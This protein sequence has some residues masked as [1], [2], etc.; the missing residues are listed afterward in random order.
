MK[1][2]TNEFVGRFLWGDTPEDVLWM[3]RYTTPVVAGS[4]ADFMACANAILL[5]QGR[6]AVATTDARTFL[7]GLEAQGVLRI[8]HREDYL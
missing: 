4:D 5:S 6:E 3:L 1:I 7:E 8:D 2:L